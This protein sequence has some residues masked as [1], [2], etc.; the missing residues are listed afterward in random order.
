MEDDTSLD[1]LQLLASLHHVD[2]VDLHADLFYKV[3]KRLLGQIVGDGLCASLLALFLQY[4]VDLPV[5]TSQICTQLFKILELEVFTE[6]DH[7]LYQV[8]RSVW[9]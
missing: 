3:T 5:N 8:L 2:T 6:G 4:G 1:G 7:I 9:S